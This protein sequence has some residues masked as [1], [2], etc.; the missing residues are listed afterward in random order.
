MVVETKRSTSPAKSD[1]SDQKHEA[2][3]PVLKMKPFAQVKSGTT[4]TSPS[5]ACISGLCWILRGLP[6]PLKRRTPRSQAGD[7]TDAAT[8]RLTTRDFSVTSRCKHKTC[9][10]QKR[11]IA[12]IGGTLGGPPRQFLEGPP[13]GSGSTDSNC[14]PA[15]TAGLTQPELNT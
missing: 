12:L 15:W 3:F 9:T 6:Q 1:P 4:R 7:L 14:G 2:G 5:E 8:V 13:I 11:I 10:E